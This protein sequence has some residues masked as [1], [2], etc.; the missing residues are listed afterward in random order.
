M[1]TGAS[2]DSPGPG[3]H[4]SHLEPLIESLA[5]WEYARSAEGLTAWEEAPEPERARSRDLARQTLRAVDDAGYEINRTADSTDQAGADPVSIPDEEGASLPRSR[6]AAERF[7]HSGD[8]LLAYNVAQ[9]GLERWPDDLRLCQ[10][11]SLALART[12]AV[13]RAN[14]TLRGLRER[15]HVDG[16]TMGLLARSHKD[17]ASGVVAGLV[18]GPAGTPRPVVRSQL[19]GRQNPSFTSPSGCSLSEG[20]RGLNHKVGSRHHRVSR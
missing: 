2:D 10:L 8:P 1:A 9:Q 13:H 5:R 7:L 15:G 12:G 14:Q 20:R 3:A 19:L 17:L 16:E 4:G 6:E 18:S 11:Q